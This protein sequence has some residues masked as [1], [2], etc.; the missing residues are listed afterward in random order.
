[1][2]RR[3]VPRGAHGGR[4]Q[5]GLLALALCCSGAVSSLSGCGETRLHP[6]IDASASGGADAG[7]ASASGG[8]AAHDGGAT[9]SAGLGPGGSAGETNPCVGCGVFPNRPVIVAPLPSDIAT[10]FGPAGSGA[11]SGGPCLIE[12]ESGSLFP[13]N[14]LPPRF[15]W[16]PFSARTAIEIRVHVDAEPS[17]L[18]VY[19]PDA[20]WTLDSATWRALASED[21]DRAIQIAT[22][23]LNLDDPKAMPALGSQATITIAPADAPGTIAYSAA[24]TAIRGFRTGTPDV[25]TLQHATAGR[26]L[27]CHTGTPGNTFI[28]YSEAAASDLPDG[29]S[30][31]VLMRLA[32]DRVSVATAVSSPTGLTLLA[33]PGQHQATFT[34]AH[35][36]AG[37]FRAITLYQQQ[38]TW[39]DL[40]ATSTDVN[41]G[42]GQLSR[43]GDPGQAASGPQWSH[44][45]TFV[46]YASGT[47]TDAGGIISKGD[48]YRVPYNAGMGGTATPIAGAS[49]AAWNEY[50]PSLSPDD[51]QV[52]YARVPRDEES[53][54]NPAAEMFV[55]PVAGG[56]PQRIRAN[57][58][59]ACLG[60]HSPGVTNSWPRWAPAATVTNGR[61][62]Y[63]LT[64]S[65]TRADGKLAQIYVTP[66]VIERAGVINTYPAIRLWNQA[67]NEANYG[68]SWTALQLP[69]G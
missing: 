56:T 12:P 61:T 5:C 24:G 17:D 21:S 45:G 20:A 40:N 48:L 23:S 57:D 54:H 6:L 8:A 46:L 62:F 53:F 69:P 47:G 26:C 4:L 41:V 68:P 63:F 34:G 58:P 39:T 60:A 9:A 1:L 11:P 37:D 22:R 27:G 67:A 16:S 35:W 15:S 25:I 14:W 30:G 55:I 44:D 3:R 31:A 59:A 42:W 19:T 50:Y 43:T 29:Q 13:R 36:A 49:D 28:A 32:R 65:S 52:A 64:F 33:R 7:G 2:I 66:V 10:R 51:R 18:V 38:L